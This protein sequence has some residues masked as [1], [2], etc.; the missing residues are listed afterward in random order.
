MV[1][2]FLGCV[3]FETSRWEEAGGGEVLF[4]RE[5]TNLL[6]KAIITKQQM[7]PLVKSIEYIEVLKNIAK[8]EK[9]KKNIAKQSLTRITS[10]H[11]VVQKPKCFCLPLVPVCTNFLKVFFFFFFYCYFCTVS[12]LGILNFGKNLVTVQVATL[13]I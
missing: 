12:F 11:E 10:K 8:K 7:E 5:V 4:R 9:K 1:R 3:E 2:V 6:K 13:L